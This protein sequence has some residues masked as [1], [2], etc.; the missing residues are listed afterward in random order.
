M[1]KAVKP[2][3]IALALLSA[4][5]AF[6]EEKSTALVNGVS[7]PQSRVEARVKAL[8]EQ[9]QPDNP[10]LRKA[11][12]ESLINLEIISQAAVK[13]GLDKTP[14]VAQQLDV[15]KQNVLAD[16]YIKE[17][18]KSHPISEDEMK[19][20][21]DTLKARGNSKDY[22]ARHILVKTEAEARDL[23]EQLKKGAK[24]DKLATTKSLDPG[25]AKQGGDLGWTVPSGFVKEFADALIALNK[26][27]V[28]APVQSQFGWHVIKLD[29][30]R[31]HKA[32]EFEQVKPQI[33]QHLQQQVIQ[34]AITDL[35]NSA[36]I[37]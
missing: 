32:P 4:N 1:L 34:K 37:E 24:F 20:E 15:I 12:R 11:I 30:V 28:S 18:L 6:A 14:D 22:K 3:L 13:Q 2:A 16:A 29:D 31:D 25:S 33:A 9:G 36:K 21:Y 7:I 35:R 5:Q 17:Y 10:E 23:V 26:G 8:V 27:Q 19:A